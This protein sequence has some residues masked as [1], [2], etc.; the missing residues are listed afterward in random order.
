MAWFNS[1][2]L[3]SSMTHSIHFNTNWV[4]C[5]YY[6]S[7]LRIRPT[8]ISFLARRLRSI[9]FIMSLC[10]LARCAGFTRHLKEMECHWQQLLP[11]TR[12]DRSCSGTVNLCH[13]WAWVSGGQGGG[14]WVCW[15]G[16]GVGLVWGGVELKTR[17]KA[18]RLSTLHKADPSL[19]QFSIFPT[20]KF[21]FPPSWSLVDQGQNN[22]E[23]L[24]LWGAPEIGQWCRACALL[25]Q[26]LTHLLQAFLL[27]T[28]GLSSPRGPLRL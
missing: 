23:P 17:G 19:Y 16:Q 28:G 8:F 2:D 10:F 14:G 26:V 15:G 5:V 20:Q 18:K 1:I 12:R 27:Q 7:P 6:R 13:P 3:H 11:K 22:K 9:V 24:P 21:V 4:P 25:T